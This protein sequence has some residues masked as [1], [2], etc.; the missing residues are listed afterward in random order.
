MTLSACRTKISALTLFISGHGVLELVE[1]KKPQY[2]FSGADLQRLYNYVVA[3]DE[4]FANP[5]NKNVLDDIKSFRF[6]LVCDGVKLKPVETGSFENLKKDKKLEHVSW[7]QLVKDTV[8]FHKDFI[9]SI[10][11]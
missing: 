7:S 2:Q 5:A 1:I 11:G 6:T 8:R 9:E 3:F 10:G 4:F